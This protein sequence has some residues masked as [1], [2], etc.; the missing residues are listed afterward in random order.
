MLA[1]PVA[2]ISNVLRTIGNTDDEVCSIKVNGDSAR[3]TDP[4]AVGISYPIPPSE[5]KVGTVK[6]PYFHFRMPF[7]SEMIQFDW[8]IHPVELGPLRYTLVRMPFEGTEN[9]DENNTEPKAEVH[10]IYHHIGLGVSMSESHSE[11][12]LLLPPC[13]DP[14]SETMIVASMLG[15]LWRLRSLDG[16]TRK[17]KPLKIFKKTLFGSPRRKS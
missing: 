12:V 14:K 6:H 2:C 1:L 16:G 3:P 15:M 5:T 7:E 4:V 11:G 10:A 8:Q 13:T 9:P 17:E